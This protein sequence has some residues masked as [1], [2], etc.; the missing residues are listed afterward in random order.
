MYA[1]VNFTSFTI[2]KYCQRN[3]KG[4]F[5]LHGHVITHVNI[6]TFSTTNSQVY[7]NIIGNQQF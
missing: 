6:K 2:A 7:Q 4:V 5:K 3:C 1:R